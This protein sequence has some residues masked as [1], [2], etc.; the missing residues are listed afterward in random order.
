MKDEDGLNEKEVLVVALVK[1]LPILEVGVMRSWLW[2]IAELVRSLEGPGREKVRERFWETLAG[3]MDVERAEVGVRWW[4]EE[5][6]RA[7]VFG[8]GERREARI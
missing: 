2:D 5:G 6:G 7:F 3:E 4:V 8:E 1:S